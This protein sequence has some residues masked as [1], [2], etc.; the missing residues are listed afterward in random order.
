MTNEIIIVVLLIG[1]LVMF[2]FNYRERKDLL[3]RIM[4]KSLVEYKDNQKPEEND[5][6]K[7][8][9]NLVSLDEAKEEI[10]G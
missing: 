8:D 9:P 2:Y 6:G 7:D 10:N 3:D 4:A 1:Q 5:F